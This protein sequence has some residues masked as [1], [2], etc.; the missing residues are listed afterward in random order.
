MLTLP[1]TTSKSPQPADGPVIIMAS[2]LQLRRLRDVPSFLAASLRIRR[3]MLGAPG[4]LGLSLI[5]RPLQLTFWTL[6]AWQNQAA[7]SATVGREPHKQIMKRFQPRAAESSFVTWTAPATE[8]PVGW[9][10]ARR[11]LEKPDFV[12]RR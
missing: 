8:L 11:R 5:A 9:D 10:E 4:A 3:Q 7:L 1:W 6:S 12:R 2:R